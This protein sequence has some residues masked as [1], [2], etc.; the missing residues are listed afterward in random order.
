MLGPHG[1]ILGHLLVAACPQR[2]WIKPNFFLNSVYMID[3]LNYPGELVHTLIDLVQHQQPQYFSA[4]YF[5]SVL[6][7]FTR[8][9]DMACTKTSCRLQFYFQ[10]VISLYPTDGP[11]PAHLPESPLLLHVYSVKHTLYSTYCGMCTTLWVF[12]CTLYN[13]Q[14]TL[15]LYSEVH[16]KVAIGDTQILWLAPPYPLAKH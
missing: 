7:L 11:L 3:N 12:F 8:L 9:D 6:Q 15:P 2:S 14:C 1:E 4:S 10:E 16:P 5:K 13:T